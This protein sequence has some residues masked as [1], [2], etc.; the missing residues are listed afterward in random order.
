MHPKDSRIIILGTESGIHRTTDRGLTWEWIR[1]GFPKTE[2][3]SFSA[4]IGAVCFDPQ[5]PHIVYAGIGRPR[6]DKSGAGTIYR[7]DDTGVT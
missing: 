3:Y 1:N 2:R 7:S 4:P 5:Q 6:W